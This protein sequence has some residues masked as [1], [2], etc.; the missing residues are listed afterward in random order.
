MI[1]EINL[2]RLK[3]G[4]N[5]F[6]FSVEEIEKVDFEENEVFIES[7]L[8][9]NLA[10][11]GN[12][13]YCTGS[14]SVDM[15]FFCDRCLD[16]FAERIEI[17]MEYVFHLGLYNGSNNDQEIIEIP[18]K[19]RVIFLDKQFKESLE[20]AIPFIKICQENCKGLCPECGTNLNENTCSCSQKKK[21]DS[22]WEKLAEIA[23]QMKEQEK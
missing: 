23:E 5:K 15:N 4:D 7:P 21:I 10:K 8:S 19:E 3:E 13:L 17:N 14:S 1:L 6:E 22:R 2:D 11:R 16:E 18:E 20:L 12:Y 9:I